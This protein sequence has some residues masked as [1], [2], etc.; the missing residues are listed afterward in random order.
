MLR[1]VSAVIRSNSIKINTRSVSSISNKND[2]DSFGFFKMFSK[3]DE[4]LIELGE[5][6][7]FSA[8]DEL[9]EM[10][11]TSVFKKL[12][13]SSAVGALCFIN[14]TPAYSFADYVF[15]S[16]VP[17]SL[18]YTHYEIYKGKRLFDSICDRF[19]QYNKFDEKTS[20]INKIYFN[21]NYSH[22]FDHVMSPITLV[23]FSMLF[24]MIRVY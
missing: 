23:G 3:K 20:L 17:L 11:E 12:L 5:T 14:A 19:N 24:E 16:V 8:I 9:S 2:S 13:A 1:V 4:K 10:I 21:N 22:V 6:E 18:C 15:L 7:D